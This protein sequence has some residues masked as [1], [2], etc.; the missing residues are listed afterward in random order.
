MVLY[1]NRVTDLI[2]LDNVTPAFNPFDDQNVGIEVG[3]TGWINLP[4]VSTGMGAEAELELFP[5]DGLD[6]FANASVSKV[7][8]NTDG[9]VVTEGSSSSFKVNAGA[10]YRTPYRTDV[11]LSLNYLSAQDWGLREFDPD[12]LAI[13]VVSSPLEARILASARIAVR[14]FVDADFELAVNAWNFTAFF[15]DGFRE[16]PEGQPITGRLYGSVAWRF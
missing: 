12:T 4:A 8:E 13:T 2:D 14:P 16:H 3:R 10:S 15:S 5:T 9:T 11:S 7:T 6:L 1:L